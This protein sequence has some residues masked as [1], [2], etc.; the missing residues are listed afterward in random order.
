MLVLCFKEQCNKIYGK[1]YKK[2]NIH[3]YLNLDEEEEKCKKGRKTKHFFLNHI[4]F[5]FNIYHC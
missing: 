3:V 5:L 1:H 2:N 4:M